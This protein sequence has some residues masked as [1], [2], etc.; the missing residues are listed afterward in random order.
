MTDIHFVRAIE[1]DLHRWLKESGQP[2]DGVEMLT[3]VPLLSAGDA[4]EYAVVLYRDAKGHVKLWTAWQYYDL[5]DADE[6][7]RTLEARA[8]AYDRIAAATRE[9]IERAKALGAK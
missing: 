4:P 8:A 2:T 1:R 3:T 9:F 7:L 5:W 6:A